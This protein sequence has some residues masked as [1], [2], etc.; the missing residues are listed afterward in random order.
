MPKLDSPFAPRL[1]PSPSIPL[2]C[3]C[4]R[5]AHSLTRRSH[6]CLSLG[7]I[8]HRIGSSTHSTRI[9]FTSLSVAS[10]DLICSLNVYEETDAWWN[11]SRKR[12]GGGW[13]WWWLWIFGGS[14]PPLSHTQ[15]HEGDS[16]KLRRANLGPILSEIEGFEGQSA[17][18]QC[19][20]NRV[21]SSQRKAEQGLAHCD[22]L[23]C[24]HIAFCRLVHFEKSCVARTHRLSH[25]LTAARLSG[26]ASSEWK[27]LGL[28]ISQCHPTLLR[29]LLLS[30]PSD[31]RHTL[32]SPISATH[33]WLYLT[34]AFLLLLIHTHPL[35]PDSAIV[36]IITTHTR[37]SFALYN[38]CLASTSTRLS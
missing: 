20:S 32:V 23:A 10:L 15:T 38:H 25:S 31:S 22:P 4:C 3:C 6:L 24:L 14:Q 12:Q 30:Q 13:L 19:K 8:V 2:D 29:L 36:S 17:L 37:L 11:R 26:S 27:E 9:I 16:A 35:P 1:P 7:R 33:C 28:A 5:T 18:N 34:F 21:E